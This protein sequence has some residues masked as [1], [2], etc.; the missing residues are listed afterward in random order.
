MKIVQTFLALVII[1]LVLSTG[2]V[3]Q[4]NSSILANRSDFPFQDTVKH[5]KNKSDSAHKKMSM[6]KHADS[7][8]KKADSVQKKYPG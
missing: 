1:V 6:K 3:R 7:T 8:K 4:G 2:L 5:S